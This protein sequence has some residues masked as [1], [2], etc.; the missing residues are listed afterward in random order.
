[1]FFLAS[2]LRKTTNQIMFPLKSC[3]FCLKLFF[4]FLKAGELFRWP[5]LDVSF[6]IFI[7]MKPAI[8]IT[9]TILEIEKHVLDES[10]MI[11]RETYFGHVVFLLSENTRKI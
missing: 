6:C 11:S 4:L 10:G 2:P 1:M 9:S 3:N 5:V 8:R 7:W